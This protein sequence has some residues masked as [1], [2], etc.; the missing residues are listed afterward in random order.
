ML[1]ANYS[2]DDGN[3]YD[4]LMQVRTLST[5][6]DLFWHLHHAYQHSKRRVRSGD[7]EGAVRL[8]HDIAVKFFK[9]GE[10]AS[11]SDAALEMLSLLKKHKLEVNSENRGDHGSRKECI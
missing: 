6:L 9:A 11:G 4:A 3:F 8:L 2:I 1:R 10:G 7:C 5:R